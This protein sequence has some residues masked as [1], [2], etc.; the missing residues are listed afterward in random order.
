[1]AKYQITHT[2]GHTETH[3]IFGTNSHGERDRKEAWFATTLCSDCYKTAKEADAAKDATEVTMKYSEYK[4]KY[5]N[6]TTKSDSY[7]STDK[8]ITVYVPKPAPVSATAAAE[9]EAIIEEMI[10]VGAPEVSAR[11][12]V[13]LSSR[14]L[15]SNI[16]SSVEKFKAAGAWNADNEKK[17]GTLVKMADIL[18]AHHR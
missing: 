11:K 8:T 16:E 4:N 14:Q 18:E 17:F 6:C 1:M 7:N 13:R 10:A 3:E 9:D 5:A 2:C 15:R 12:I